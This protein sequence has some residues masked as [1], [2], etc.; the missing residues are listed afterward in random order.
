MLLGFK[1]HMRV[2]PT[3]DKA[4]VGI[5]GHAAK[6]ATVHDEGKTE[7]GI[8]Y[9]SRNLIRYS[10]EDVPAIDRILQR[11]VMAQSVFNK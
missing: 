7:N 11:Y 1:R 5:Y 8:K 9:P 2:K 3:T 4:E 10:I 6:V